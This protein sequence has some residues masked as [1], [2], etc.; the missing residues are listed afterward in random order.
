[1]LCWYVDAVRNTCP[2]WKARKS[3]RI[4]S[5]NNLI[6]RLFCRTF[7]RQI[8]MGNFRRPGMADSWWPCCSEWVFG[9]IK[10]PRGHFSFLHR[11]CSF[12]SLSSCFHSAKS[13][14]QKTRYRP[15]WAS[16]VRV[17]ILTSYS[18]A[19]LRDRREYGSG[20]FPRCAVGE[21]RRSCLYRGA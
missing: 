18:L 17:P 21:S 9:V 11:F 8:K 10:R 7:W 15:K 6:C 12:L 20:F 14:I 5:A 1:M 3:S 13:G 2:S 19:L 16:H 4:W